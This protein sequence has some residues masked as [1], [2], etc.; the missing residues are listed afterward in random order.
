MK[1]AIATV[2]L[3]N[4]RTGLMPWRYVLELAQFLQNHDNQVDVLNSFVQFAGEN[5]AYKGLNIIRTTRNLKEFCG[6]MSSGNYDVLIYPMPLRESIKKLNA[7]CKLNCKKIAYMPGGIYPPGSVF[8]LLINTGLKTALPYFL[9]VLTPEWFYA[10]Q[11]K[12][13]GFDTFAGLTPF[14]T[15]MIKKGGF[16]KAVT[17]LPGKDDFEKI[18]EDTLIPEKYSLNGK[19]YFLFTGN[20]DPIRGSGILLKQIDKLALKNPDLLFVFLIRSDRK[21]SDTFF[22]KN[23]NKIKHKDNLLVIKD[24]L[25]RSELKSFFINAHAIILPFL[26]IPSEIPLTFPEVLSFGIPV[27]T[28]N[29]GG[30][31]KYFK[32]VILTAK[33]V[34]DLNLKLHLL[35]N[36]DRL[37]EQL[38]QKSV[39][40]MKNYPSWND[41][42]SAWINLLK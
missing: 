34:R 26:V 28:F 13:C 38:S 22:N 14:T 17:I 30:T 6:F 10:K 5:S 37:R 18:V 9:D 11:L 41:S 3:L 8:R 4:E 7:L 39:E 16:E 29:N 19:K 32:D 20:T 40:C 35:W 2:D 1:I 31:T 42:L 15:G 33:N 36:D 27:I 12:K 23:L 21:S 25:N 24:L